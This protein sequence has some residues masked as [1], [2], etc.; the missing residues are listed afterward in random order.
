MDIEDDL[1]LYCFVAWKSNADAQAD[2]YSNVRSMGQAINDNVVV[3]ISDVV[4]KGGKST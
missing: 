4:G 2:W 3:A 1:V